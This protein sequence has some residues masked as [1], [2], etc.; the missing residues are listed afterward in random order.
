MS[1]PEPAALFGH[2]AKATE[3]TSFQRLHVTI[4]CPHCDL[5]GTISSSTPNVAQAVAAALIAEHYRATDTTT[6]A[7]V[8][9]AA[10]EVT[11]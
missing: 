3:H 11:S 6:D 10:A 1:T 4:A 8:V 2:T 5:T 7:T 9:L